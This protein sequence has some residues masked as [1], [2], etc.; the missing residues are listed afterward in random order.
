[1]LA[2]HS[3]FVLSL[4]KDGRTGLARASMRRRVARRRQHQPSVA[5]SQWS[6]MCLLPFAT[7]A[8]LQLAPVA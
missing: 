4:S 8:P 5:I 3:T 6:F 1:M 7:S 2:A